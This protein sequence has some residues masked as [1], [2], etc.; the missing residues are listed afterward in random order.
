MHQRGEVE[1][2]STRRHCADALAMYSL[3]SSATPGTT[4]GPGQATSERF[5]EDFILATWR[6]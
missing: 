5:V 3:P 2:A 6:A 4:G 1:G